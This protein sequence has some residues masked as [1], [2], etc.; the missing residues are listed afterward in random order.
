MTAR[1]YGHQILP[2]TAAQTRGVL[3]IVRKEASV[4]LRRGSPL[5]AVQV[6]LAA[7]LIPRGG[8]ASFLGVMLALTSAVTLGVVVMWQQARRKE[9][10]ILQTHPWEVWPCR[11]EKV[12]VVSSSGTRADGRRWS[13][14]SRL[15]LLRPDG[16]AQCSFPVPGPGIKDTV[17]FA[18]D[19]NTSGILAVPGGLPFRHVTRQGRRAR[20]PAPPA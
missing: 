3:D 9:L 11:G 7:L 19:I 6:C 16:Q 14:G 1:E 8:P 4:G 12:R 5:L 2:G 20:P 15:V 17:W 13:T 10:R 18:G